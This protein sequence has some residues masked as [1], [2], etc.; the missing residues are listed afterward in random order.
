MTAAPPSADAIIAQTLQLYK[1]WEGIEAQFSVE[2]LQGD[3]KQTFDGTITVRDDKFALTTPD[4]LVWFDG[5]TQCTYLVGTDEV[6]ISEPTGS[7]LRTINPLFFLRDYKKD[8]RAVYVGE[9]T[10][11]SARAAYDVSLTPRKK[12]DVEKIDIQIEK[13]SHQPS[14]IV[15]TLTNGMRN[16]ITINAIKACKPSDEDFTFPAGKYPNAEVIDLR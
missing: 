14:R 2:A 8:F 5:K 16:I 4:M 1:Q 11:P 15:V 10:S 6:N 13:T 12:D 7:E 9:S 3:S